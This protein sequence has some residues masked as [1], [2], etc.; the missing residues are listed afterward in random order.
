MIMFNQ[1]GDPKYRSAAAENSRT[2]LGIC[3]GVAATT[4]GGLSKWDTKEA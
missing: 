1:G 4:V 3:Y 2:V